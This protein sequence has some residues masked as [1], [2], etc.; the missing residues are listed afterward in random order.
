MKRWAKHELT[1]VKKA[2]ERR[3]ESPNVN[4]A[5]LFLH[6]TPIQRVEIEWRVKLNE[7][8]GEMSSNVMNS[9]SFLHSMKG[10]KHEMNESRSVNEITSLHQIKS[11][12][13]WLID[14]VKVIEYYNSIYLVDCNKN[15]E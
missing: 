3:M 7:S 10:M 4:G 2:S 6:F 13:I 1:E 14:S 9:I 15:I 8:E 11:N 12:E 5:T